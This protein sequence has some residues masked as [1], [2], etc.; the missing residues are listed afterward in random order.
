MAAVFPLN[1]ICSLRFTVGSSFRVPGKDSGADS[2]AFL[3]GAGGCGSPGRFEEEV[4]GRA[5][6]GSVWAAL[7][8]VLKSM[9]ESMSDAMMAPK[10]GLCVQDVADLLV[11]AK[12]AIPRM[13]APRA[14]FV[15]TC[16]W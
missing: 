6:P 7:K 3:P 10:A 9:F 5:T 16:A 4:N 15:C 11:K 1:T 13:T 2:V 14:Q 8:S 12:A